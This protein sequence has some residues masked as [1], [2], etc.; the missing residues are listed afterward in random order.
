MIGHDGFSSLCEFAGRAKPIMMAM[1]EVRKKPGPARGPVSVCRCGVPA[2]S[3]GNR[4]CTGWLW[5]ETPGATA[6]R[7]YA[8][9]GSLRQ[10]LA[11]HVSHA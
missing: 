11:P 2:S 1:N 8:I 4:L 5:E 6:S 10:R 7:N 3:E 9:Q